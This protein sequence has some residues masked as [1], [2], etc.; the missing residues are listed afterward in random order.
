VERDVTATYDSETGFSTIPV[1]DSSVVYK[2]R[3]VECDYYIRGWEPDDTDLIRRIP[4]EHVDGVDVYTIAP[5]TYP[6][7][8]ETV[9][10]H[11]LDALYTYGELA[12]VE[13]ALNDFTHFRGYQPNSREGGIDENGLQNIH[14]NLYNK[15]TRERDERAMMLPIG[16][17]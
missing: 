17:A 5:I 13:M 1:T 3:D 2:L 10:D 16:I 4:G 15:W 9:P 6:T 7:T 14:T 11:W 12:L 8:S